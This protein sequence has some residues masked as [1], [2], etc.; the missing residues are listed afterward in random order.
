METYDKIILY[1]YG[2]VGS[3]TLWKSN[4]GEHYY[5]KKDEYPEKFIH[6]HSHEVAKD[7]LAKYEDKKLL[8]INIVRLPIDRKLSGFFQGIQRT[9]RG[10]DTISM[11]LLIKF[12][13]TYSKVSELERWM[14]YY[15]QIND[16]DMNMQF[17][18][19]NKHTIIKKNNKTFLFFRYEDYQHICQTILYPKY[20]ILYNNTTNIDDN[21]ASGL[22]YK[23]IK[24]AYKVSKAEEKY[25]NNAFF[26]NK[27]YTKDEIN[28]QVN[29]YNK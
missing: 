14:T 4:N 26:V 24:E 7:I 21:K 16:I 20:G 25:I 13:N 17:D 3:M 18:I 10:W 5:N 27:F 28:Q 11:D 15:F 8:I 22:R 19:E 29:K 6:V 23:E 12:A 2:K 1:Q 9:L